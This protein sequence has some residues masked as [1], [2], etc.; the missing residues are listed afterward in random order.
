MKKYLLIGLTV[1]TTAT[2]TAAESGAKEKI[3][4]AAKKLGDSPNYSW[5]TTPKDE[6]GSSGRNIGPIEGKTEKAGYTYLIITP[7]G[8]SIEIF[9]KGEKGA[10]KTLE[11]WQSFA[12]IEQAGGGA[13]AI[14]RR[15][16]QWKTPAAEAVD[17]LGGVKEL[18]EA[19][20]AYAGELSEDKVKELILLAARRREGQPPPEMK[21]LKGSVKFWLKD[22]ALPKYEF[23]LQGKVTAGEREIDIN[24]TMVVEVKDVGST[25]IELPDEAK[26]A[27]K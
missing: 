22:S 3:I 25:K 12:D 15:I 4:A 8:V 5:T 7:G 16:R 17:L 6:T 27:L 14:A 9:M 10:A 24:Q 21:T 1:V 13:A 2:L 20:G 11:G 18:K 26:T 19:D 23:N